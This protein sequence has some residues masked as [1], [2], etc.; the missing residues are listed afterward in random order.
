MHRKP[1]TEILTERGIPFVVREDGRVFQ[2]PAGGEGDGDTSDDPPA[3]GDAPVAD[4]IAEMEARFEKRFADQERQHQESMHQMGTRL[5][6]VTGG[7]NALLAAQA[8]G[9]KVE[10]PVIRIPTEDDIAAAYEE[11][12]FRKAARLS[13][14]MAEGI[15]KRESSTL[16]ETELNPL[17]QTVE[18]VGLPAM[19]NLTR[20]GVLRDLPEHARKFYEDNKG[21]VHAHF[22]RVD[23]QAQV[24]PEAFRGALAY[25]MGQALL[26]GDL[27]KRIAEEA[28]R[29]IR[30]GNQPGAIR[31]GGRQ[32]GGATQEHDWEK[33]FG[34]GAAAAAEEN[35]GWDA[36]ARNMGYADMNDY[37]TKTGVIGNA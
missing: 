8:A 21:A 17:R 19:A 15:A 3:D 16:R 30:S 36:V 27:D 1:L 22:G 5:A 29:Q 10:A 18:N 24:D 12:D 6:E 37:A 34:A 2:I 26:R 14:E 20:T 33:I 25:E 9:Q 4:P 28:E 7:Y 13:R 23:P 35:G 11:G 32:D 31:P